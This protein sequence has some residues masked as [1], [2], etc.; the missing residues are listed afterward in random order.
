MNGAGETGFLHVE[1]RNP[2]LK[3]FCLKQIKDLNIRAGTMKRL[4][5]H[6]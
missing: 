4:K 3:K 5:E 2:S 6:K 1:K